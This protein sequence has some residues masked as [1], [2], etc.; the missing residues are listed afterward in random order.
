MNSN[1]NNLP[2]GKI[3]PLTF[4]GKEPLIP[5]QVSID[6]NATEAQYKCLCKDGSYV[7]IPHSKLTDQTNSE[8]T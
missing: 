1:S 5:V 7:M 4:E 6:E 8:K 2:K 3:L